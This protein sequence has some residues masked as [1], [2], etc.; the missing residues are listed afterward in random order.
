LLTQTIYRICFYLLFLWSFSASLIYTLESKNLLASSWNFLP[1]IFACLI[2]Y[3]FVWLR[4]HS[5]NLKLSLNSNVAIVSLLVIFSYIVSNFYWFDY[6]LRDLFS[7]IHYMKGALELNRF[8][9]YNPFTA[10]SYLPTMQIA[11]AIMD[12]VTPFNILT[13]VWIMPIF[14]ILLFVMI[15]YLLGSVFCIVEKNKSFF[16]FGLASLS[17]PIYYS[18]TLLAFFAATVFLYKLKYFIDKDI[19]KKSLILK[20][21]LLS[22]FILVSVFAAKFLFHN[23]TY[24]FFALSI[25]G[26]ISIFER[27]YTPLFLLCLISNSF[28]RIAPLF[29]GLS[30]VILFISKQVNEFDKSKLPL[31]TSLAFLLGNLVLIGLPPVLAIIEKKFNLS[32]KTD[33]FWGVINSVVEVFY[34]YRLNPHDVLSSGGGFLESFIEW[35][36]SFPPSA[37]V[38]LTGVN[39]LKLIK[40][41]FTKRDIFLLSSFVLFAFIMNSALPFAYRGSIYSLILFVILSFRFFYYLD[42]NLKKWLFFL[43]LASNLTLYI[44]LVSPLTG[45]H[46]IYLKNNPSFLVIHLL[47]ITA[48]YSV[49]RKLKQRSWLILVFAIFYMERQVLSTFFYKYSYG[50]PPHSNKVI[51]HYTQNDLALA[52]KVLQR[53]YQY[54]FSDPIT[55]SIAKST[56]GQNGSYSYQNINGLESDRKLMVKEALLNIIKC[57]ESSFAS[58]LKQIIDYSFSGE[59]MYFSRKKY[60]TSGSGFSNNIIENTLVVISESTLNWINCPECSGY[61]PKKADLNISSDCFKTVTI[62]NQKY[63]LKEINLPQKMRSQAQDK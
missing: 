8:N 6:P 22:T 2:C 34:G 62:N 31:R 41:D 16:I 56:T 50:I 1:Y 63:Y 44:L 26:L 43:L 52:E 46:S 13:L 19:S 45:E 28:H 57:D 39:L 47:F 23:K 54:I 7:S 32:I 17:F 12:K 53:K 30:L 4:P 24:W 58:V 37:Y 48:L 49:T 61:F 51:T 9:L 25:T 11:L 60:S 14:N 36:R 27:K 15:A 21:I 42:D 10:D 59:A 3:P 18:P 38:L 20:Y 5:K 40:R 35:I 55:M 33:Y 29:L